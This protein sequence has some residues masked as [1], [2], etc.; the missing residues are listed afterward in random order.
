MDI[1][2]IVLILDVGHLALLALR[3]RLG[4]SGS[5]SFALR[6]TGCSFVGGSDSGRVDS[7]SFHEALIPLG[8][9]RDS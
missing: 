1:F 4:R 3:G 8:A 6:G 7:V 2:V 5:G 9:D